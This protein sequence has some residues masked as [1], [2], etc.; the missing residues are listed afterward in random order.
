MRVKS[1]LMWVDVHHSS[2]WGSHV[3]RA[4]EGE[5]EL[6]EDEEVGTVGGPNT[7]MSA[8]SF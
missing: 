4:E 5:R 1:G 7:N 2:Q 6:G 8:Q 3:R